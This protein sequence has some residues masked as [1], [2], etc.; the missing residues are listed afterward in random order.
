MELLVIWLFFGAFAG[1]L[2]SNKGKNGFVWFLFGV[3][4]GPFAVLFAFFIKKDVPKQEKA[5]FQRAQNTEEV[6]SSFKYILNK[7]THGDIYQNIKKDILD[8]VNNTSSLSTIKQNDNDVL[9]IVCN[10]NKDDYIK[11][12]SEVINHKRFF[13]VDSLH[14]GEIDNLEVYDIVEKQTLS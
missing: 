14:C 1:L 10:Y 8:Y 2:A 7:P 11:L 12:Y 13:I 6:K 9:L 5:T 3:F 4:A